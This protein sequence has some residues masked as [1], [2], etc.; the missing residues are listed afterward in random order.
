M[1]EN[2]A[3]LSSYV[4]HFGVWAPAVVF[5][6]FVIQAALPVFPYIILAAGSGMLFG[7]KVGV[8]LAWSGALTGACLCYWVCRLA[9]YNSFSKWL[10]T[11]YGYN[12]ENHKP[13]TAF[14]SIVISRVLP[15]VP[16]PLINA[17]AALG[18]VSFPNFLLASAIGKIP[19]AVLYTGLG[20]ALFNAKDV[21]TILLIIA[22]AIMLLLGIKLLA[23]KF[24]A[25]PEI[26]AMQSAQDTASPESVPEDVPQAM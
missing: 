9:G 4:Q 5:I 13:S 24:S 21:D 16:T 2:L 19:T 25:I 8:L 1:F 20:L 22:A 10:F 23:R 15:F 7:F 17:V 11:H 6:L 12:M 3:M 18:G 14:W 26:S